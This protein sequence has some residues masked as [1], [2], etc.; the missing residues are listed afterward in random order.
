MNLLFYFLSTY[1]FDQVIVSFLELFNNFLSNF[2]NLIILNPNNILKIKYLIYFAS[3]VISFNQRAL[4][5]KDFINKV[6]DHEENSRIGINDINVDDISIYDDPILPLNDNHIISEILI[7][8]FHVLEFYLTTMKML[9]FN[10]SETS[11]NKNILKIMEPGLFYFL[12]N[13]CKLFLNKN[14][15][16]KYFNIFEN[17]SET[18]KLKD[19]TMILS[20]IISFLVESCKINQ[21]SKNDHFHYQKV[22]KIFRTIVSNAYM[23]ID[24]TSG[25]KLLY[26]GKLHIQENFLNSVLEMPEILVKLDPISMGKYRT[27]FYNSISKIMLMKTSSRNEDLFNL[28]LKFYTDNIFLRKDSIQGN[29]KVGYD[30][31]GY[32]Q[33]L[34]GIC[35]SISLKEDYKNFISSVH[36]SLLILIQF[37]K[38]NSHIPEVNIFTLKLIEEI[39]NN[40]HERIYFSQNCK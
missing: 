1:S 33:D 18:F 19:N 37:Y 24:V 14:L 26:I 10:Q 32:L 25:E 38:E 2:K 31:L 39:T 5:E 22:I 7:K 29:E 17:I 35:S 21:I 3:A 9:S 27:I 34:K 6:I 23:S 4:L 28:V 36:R 40:K 13:F 16:G 15:S 12:K 8:I 20:F 11:T 30:F